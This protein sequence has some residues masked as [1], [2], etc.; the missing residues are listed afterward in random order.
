MNSF[1][2][3]IKF[4]LLLLVLLAGF[5]FALQNTTS[6]GLWLIHDFAPKPVSLW[7]L[8]AFSCGGLSGLVLG[9]GMWRRIRMGWQLRQLQSELQQCRQELAAL[10]RERDGEQQKLM[11]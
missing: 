10:R 5:V 4:V 3:F 8:L 2:G 11:P 9:Y 7:L 1:A 6:V